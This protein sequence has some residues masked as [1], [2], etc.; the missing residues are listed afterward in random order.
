MQIL[1]NGIGVP[2][3]KG[4]GGPS[5]NTNFVTVWETENP[6]SATKTITL[7]LDSGAWT[8][9]D[10]TI[11]WGDG[12][13]DTLSYAN[14]THVYSTTGTK[15]ITI[16]ANSIISGWYFLNGRDRRKLVDVQNWGDQFRLILRAFQGCN[17]MVISATDAPTISSAITSAF[18]FCDALT[19]EDFSH[20]DV[21]GTTTLANTFNNCNNFNG[22]INNWVHSGVTTIANM[23]KDCSSFNGDLNNW[24]TSGIT[25]WTESFKNC[26][27]FN[28][29]VSGWVINGS[30]STIFQNSYAF[31]GNGMNT[32]NVSGCTSLNKAFVN[33]RLLNAD[34][35]G[36]NVSN[37]TQMSEAFYGCDV[38]NQKFGS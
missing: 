25:T 19:D 35:T 24:D 22:N 29:N 37:V 26:N 2:F 20:W 9:F 36:W 23:L 8:N 5:V 18:E 15:T 28:G 21:T 30:F 38:F 11:D 3:R 12:N 13:T 31:T 16:S 27:A 34:I 1:G 7:P 17:N 4:G 33:C 32:W 6:G 10:G 14:R